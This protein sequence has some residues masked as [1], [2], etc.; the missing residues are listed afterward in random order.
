MP[1]TA[2]DEFQNRW[3]TVR[4]G[5]ARIYQKVARNPPKSGAE[6]GPRVQ[7]GW[8]GICRVCNIRP[9]LISCWTS[10]GLKSGLRDHMFEPLWAHVG[11]PRGSNPA[12]EMICLVHFEL[13]LDLPGALT[14]VMGGRSR[15]RAAHLYIQTPSM[16][17]DTSPKCMAPMRSDRT[18]A[19]ELPTKPNRAPN[20]KTPH[21]KQNGFQILH[22]FIYKLPIHRPWWP[23]CYA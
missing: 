22:S 5:R 20:A 14:G 1:G 23:L 18:N 8:R 2:G 3:I 19:R 7:I 21:F 17:A 9:L 6:S 15:E 16:W 13:I 4:I 10:P 12:S 11:P